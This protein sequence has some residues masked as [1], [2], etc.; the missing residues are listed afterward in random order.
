MEE[1]ELEVDM[2][3]VMVMAMAMVMVM[4]MVMEMVLEV[5]MD[6]AISLKMWFKLGYKRRVQTRAKARSIT[7][8]LFTR[9]NTLVI[10]GAESTGQRDRKPSIM[11]G[12][13]ADWEACREEREMTPS[14]ASRI[15]VEKVLNDSKHQQGRDPSEP[16]VESK[17]LAKRARVDPETTVSDGYTHQGPSSVPTRAPRNTLRSQRRNTS[18]PGSSSTNAGPSKLTPAY[19]SCMN[20]KTCYLP[21][22]NPSLERKCK[23]CG[24]RLLPSQLP[25]HETQ[26]VVSPYAPLPAISPSDFPSLLPQPGS[27]PPRGW[28][29]DAPIP[30]SVTWIKFDDGY[31]LLNQFGQNVDAVGELVDS[32]YYLISPNTG[33]R[34]RDLF[35]RVIRGRPI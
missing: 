5:F 27:L 9:A 17:R 13:L 4:V 10:V 25:A 33:E 6:T 28:P 2:D 26:P 24:E 20:C 7:L 22:D 1:L 11:E 14:R 3:T 12:N 34:R 23:D 21:A 15:A 29:L 32:D 18:T 35:D 8:L 16:E 31:G 19:E 30:T